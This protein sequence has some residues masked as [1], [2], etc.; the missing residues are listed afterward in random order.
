MI[1]LGSVVIGLGA[2]VLRARLTG[3]Q[4][5]PLDIRIGWIVILAVLPQILSFQ[6]PATGKLIPESFVPYIL[7]GSQALLLVFAAAN[8]RRPGFWAM[9]SGLLAN[10]T[11]IA[12]NGGWMPISED[13]LRRM[14][15]Y[16]SP[17]MNITNQRLLLTKDWIM[18]LA[19]TRLAWLSDTLTIPGMTIA[20]SIGDIFIA[21]GA[22]LLF[23]SLSSAS[24]RGAQV[25]DKQ[26]D[27]VI[28][29][30]K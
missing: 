6:I 9:G 8:L 24:K 15:P 22:F 10:F 13:T 26:P 23:W 12:L 11:V 5:K 7:V 30:Q 28:E 16:L 20:F 18:P 17:E 19:E 21:F 4:L 27:E 29:H 1:L 2:T 25:S 3:R 14:L